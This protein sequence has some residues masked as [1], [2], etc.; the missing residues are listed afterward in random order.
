L[1]A[2]ALLESAILILLEKDDKDL[3]AESMMQLLKCLEHIT[4][5]FTSIYNLEKKEK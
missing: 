1:K 5:I 4:A 2:F 3:A